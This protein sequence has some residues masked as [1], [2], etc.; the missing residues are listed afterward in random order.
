MAECLLKLG[1]ND[2]AQDMMVEAADIRKENN[3]GL[4]AL[5]AGQVQAASGQRIIE[6]RIKEA[7]KES[8]NLPEYWRQRAEY[9][10]G[11]NEPAKEE[12]ALKKGL[13]ITT[14]RAE[15]V[16]SHL[17]GHAD[18]RSWLLSDYAHFLERQKR[19]EDAVEL[20]RKEI[21][22][23]PATSGSAKSA[24]HLLAFDF[25]K[26]VRVDDDILWTWLA[27]RPKWEDKIDEYFSRAEK[28][29]FEHDASRAYTLGWIMNRMRFPKRSIALIEYAVKNADDKELKKKAIFTLFESYLDT[30]DWMRAEQ[31]FPDA[32]RN[33]TPTEVPDWY[34]RIAAIAAQAGQKVDAMRIWKAVANIDPAE[35]G[36]LNHLAKAGLR[37]ELVTFYKQMQQKLPSSEIPLRAL[38]SLEQQ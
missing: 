36:N 38:R 4:N 1:R 33:L 9:Y 31:I 11:R 14:P 17:R 10:R 18:W 8:E 27:N 15:E 25:E 37:D 23:A 7:E 34:S 28:L 24:A 35:L 22:Q 21:E 3:L 20:L 26:K 32:R 13:A 12:E 6:G 29:A 19:I 16:E 5:F 2:E 30:G